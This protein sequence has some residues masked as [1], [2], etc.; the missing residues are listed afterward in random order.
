MVAASCKSGESDHGGSQ[1]MFSTGA[2]QTL[3]NEPSYLQALHVLHEGAGAALPGRKCPACG[4]A[5]STVACSVMCRMQKCINARCSH[6]S[7][8]QVKGGGVMKLRSSDPL[9]LA[10]VDAWWSLLLPRLKRFMHIH[11][12]STLMVQVCRHVSK[13]IRH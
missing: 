4:N 8:M 2:T 10:Q 1:M 7:L 5:P 3:A 6:R 9:W 12:G 13:L 11:G